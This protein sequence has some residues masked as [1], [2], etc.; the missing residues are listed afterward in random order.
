MRTSGEGESTGVGARDEEQAETVPARHRT[1]GDGSHED[2]V[3]DPALDD[4]VGSDWA[5]E[6]G[7]TSS[8]PATATAADEE[9]ADADGPR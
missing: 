8:G 9:G 3:T 2:V 7:A 5:D 4:R 6:G 1:D